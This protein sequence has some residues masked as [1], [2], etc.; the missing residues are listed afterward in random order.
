MPN[1]PPLVW[2][3]F[4]GVAPNAGKDIPIL[5]GHSPSLLRISKN[6]TTLKR[7]IDDLEHSAEAYHARMREQARREFRL[8]LPPQSNLDIALS[9][10][11]RIRKETTGSQESLGIAEEFR[12]WV[13]SEHV[14]YPGS[15]R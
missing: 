11:D 12:E 2:V 14:K 4:G 8:P 10:W 7:R 1:P 6:M 3:P 15:G 13:R 5:Y 9:F